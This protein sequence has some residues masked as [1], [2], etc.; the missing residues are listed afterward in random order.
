MFQ[1][2]RT[3][4]Q[5]V[6]LP[7]VVGM[8]F[9]AVFPKVAGR[10]EPP[11]SRIFEI[12]LVVVAVLL[13]IGTYSLLLKMDAWS[14]VVMIIFI[15]VNVALGHVLGPRDAQERTTLAI[16]SGERNTGLA[17]TI[18]VLNFSGGRTLPVLI[19]YIILYIVISSLYLKW[20]ERDTAT[21]L[22]SIQPS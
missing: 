20:R 11:L 5:A 4:V 3:V 19:P 16:E 8:V 10:I 22:R 9:G 15:V 7:V 2:G 18:G 6:L 1:V 21:G 17:M 13:I 14:Y 12:G